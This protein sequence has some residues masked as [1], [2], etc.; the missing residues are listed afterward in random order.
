L[1]RVWIRAGVVLGVV[2]CAILRESVTR[3]MS[4]P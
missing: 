2:V 4:M 3:V 1:M